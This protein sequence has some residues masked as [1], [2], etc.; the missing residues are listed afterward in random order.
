MKRALLAAVVLATVAA[1]CSSSSTPSPPETTP[2]SGAPTT[3]APTAGPP[4]GATVRAGALISPGDLGPGWSTAPATSTPC[5][6]TYPHTA[7]ARTGLSNAR[8]TLTETIALVP[9]V[10]A[11]V[12]TWQRALTACGFQVRQEQL[13]DAGITADR[14]GDS[15]ALTGTEGVLVVLHARGG[16]AG[17]REELEGW[18]DLALGTSC[19]A[20]PDGCH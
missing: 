7:S 3:G 14:P 20:A 8:G 10:Q 5:T 12:S 6:P 1:S 16:L 17:A 18:A 4:V 19:V 15:V 9:D 2:T 13:G 11:A